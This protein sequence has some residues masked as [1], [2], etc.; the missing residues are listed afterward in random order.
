MAYN[1]Y[2]V[3]SIVKT[4]LPILSHSA[5]WPHYFVF[6]NLTFRI[7]EEFNSGAQ[8]NGLRSLVHIKQCPMI[9]LGKTE[10]SGQ[11]LFLLQNG[12]PPSTPLLALAGT[13]EHQTVQSQKG[14]MTR[15]FKCWG[16]PDSAGQFQE[17]LAT[18]SPPLYLHFPCHFTCP[19][20][21]P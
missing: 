21:S 16:S 20:C 15:M 6:P 3:A 11:G 12:G 1:F 10:Q 18:E 19:K 4:E 9:S 13:Q 17:S 5:P 8:K 7:S 2:K 14:M